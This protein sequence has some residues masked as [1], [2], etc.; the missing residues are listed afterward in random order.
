MRL[1]CGQSL[2][3]EMTSTSFQSISTF[4]Y[5]NFIISRKHIGAT[6][7]GRLMFIMKKQKKAMTFQLMRSLR[8]PLLVP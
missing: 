4:P 3:S 6:C 5:T 2:F 8:E 1:E 7:N